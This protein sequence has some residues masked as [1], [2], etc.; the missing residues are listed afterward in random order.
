M[1][2]AISKAAATLSRF[3]SQR[4]PP[5]IGP[6]RQHLARI[7]EEP[8]VGGGKIFLGGGCFQESCTV[9]TKTRIDDAEVTATGATG[10]RKGC[11]A[12]V[13]EAEFARR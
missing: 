5:F 8:G 2:G 1:H 9:S 10:A 12:Y 7:I 11:A 3:I 13:E 4:M 6:P